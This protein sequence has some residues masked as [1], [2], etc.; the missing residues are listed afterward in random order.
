MKSGLLDL[1]ILAVVT[2]L[3]FLVAAGAVGAFAGLAWK[4]AQWVAA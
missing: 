3:S 4:V 1:A 2:V